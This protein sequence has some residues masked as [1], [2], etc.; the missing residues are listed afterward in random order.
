[1]QL[2]AKPFDRQTLLRS[3]RAALDASGVD[4]S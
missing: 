4:P 3:V 2:V 1:M